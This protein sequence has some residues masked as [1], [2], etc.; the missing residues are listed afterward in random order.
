MVADDG[1]KSINKNRLIEFMMMLAVC[2]A[3]FYGWYVKVDYRMNV[4]EKKLDRIYDDVYKPFM[5]DRA[6]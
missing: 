2:G 3:L 5:G 4:M 6:R 1:S